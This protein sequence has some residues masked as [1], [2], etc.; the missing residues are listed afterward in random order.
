MLCGGEAGIGKTRLVT[1]FCRRAKTSGSVILAGGCVDLGVGGLPYGPFAEALRTAIARATLDPA[2]LHADVVDQLA[3]LVPDLGRTQSGG[4]VAGA[5]L[6]GL[7]QV[8]LFEAVLATLESIAT[9][10]S[11]V[12]VIED[13]HW[14]DRSTQ[15]LLSF[16][17]R[18]LETA[19]FMIIATVRTDGVERG[20]PLAVLLGELSRRPSVERLDLTPLD[21]AG[22]VAQVRGILGDDA[23]DRLLRRI[24]RRSDG[25]P[26]FI[27]QLAHAHLDG[28]DTLIPGSLRDILLTQLSRQPP[29]VQALLSAAAVA[30]PRA[31]EALLAEMLGCSEAEI[32]SPLREAVRAWMLVPTHAD[33]HEAYSFRHA[34]MEEAVESDLLDGDRRWL[35]ARCAEALV[36]R[37]QTSGAALA[38]RAAQIAHHRDAAGDIA[39]TITASIDAALAAEGVAA[40]ADALNRYERAIQLLEEAPGTVPHTGWDAAEVFHRAAVCAAIS[41]APADA[42]RLTRVALD[43]LPAE[44]DPFRRGR[45]LID[46]GEQLWLAGDDGFV[47]ALKHAANVIPAHPPTSVRAEALVALGYH[48]QITGQLQDAWDAFDEALATALAIGSCRDEAMARTSLAMML[49]ERGDTAGVARELAAG[50]AAVRRAPSAANTSVVYLD[51]AAVAGWSGHDE[52]GVELSLEGIAAAQEHGSSTYYGAALAASGAE[53]L[54]SLGRLREAS[55]LIDTA[56]AIG[57]S[58]WSE[59]ARR[60]TRA[61]VL[62]ALGALDRARSDMDATARWADIG[63]RTIGRWRAVVDAEL[64][65]ED[66]RPEDVGQIVSDGLAL[67]STHV[68]W[69]DHRACLGWLAIRAGADLAELARARRDR[70]EATIRASAVAAMA[71]VTSMLVGAPSELSPT[72]RRARAYEAMARAE[73]SRVEGRSEPGLW[74]EAVR[75]WDGLNW[76]LRPLYARIRE[77]E[78]RLEGPRAD[79]GT[80]TRL[81]VDAHREAV[82]REARTLESMAGSLA[83]RARIILPAEPTVPGLQAVGPGLTAT[84]ASALYGLTARELE[85][86]AL[87][88]AGLTNR[89]IGE[90]LFISP[91]TAGVHVSNILGK[92]G[93]TG[94]VQAASVAHRLGLSVPREVVSVGTGSRG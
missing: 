35:H 28:E 74:A 64:T 5:E 91:K 47:D 55:E 32:L 93:V 66:G 37:R 12:L 38:Q 31:D 41:G 22:T 40:H 89:E 19:G 36:A 21:L 39:G 51:L 46:L 25:N 7:G 3:I 72:Q 18:N 88:A 85:I 94:R 65:L 20:A 82:Q 30:G 92:L 48:H 87:L 54:W 43:R 4:S 57:V 62:T 49:L 86:L 34:L 50:M 56:D 45:L 81:L 6:G 61:G 53:G 90:R 24:H 1:E 70:S 15:D 60:I 17:V 8:R 84:N 75:A 63:D 78:A 13:L 67:P 16:L 33:E 77:A 26:Y 29:D 79:R 27:E 76:V 9:E 23:D 80:A 73:M 69:A 11:V 10:H 71:E 2:R 52:L 14:A 44:S 58:G 68:P 59:V 42:V 83:S